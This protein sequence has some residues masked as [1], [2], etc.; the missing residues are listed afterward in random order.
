MTVFAINPLFSKSYY[1]SIE[2]KNSGVVVNIPQIYFKLDDRKLDDL[3]VEGVQ[4]DIFLPYDFDVNNNKEYD[5]T[6]EYV[7]DLIA[8]KQTQK[9]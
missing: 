1:Q 7:L 5:A 2:L 9:D 4:P 3:K 8:E 6:M